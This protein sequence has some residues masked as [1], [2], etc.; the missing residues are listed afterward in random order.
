MDNGAVGLGRAL[1][2]VA[3]GLEHGER[4]IPAGKFARNSAADNARTNYYDIIF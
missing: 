3:A 2:D 4:N 1:G